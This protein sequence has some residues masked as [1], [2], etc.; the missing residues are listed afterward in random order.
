MN[1]LRTDF[2]RAEYLVN[3][4]VSAAT[5]KERDD[6]GFKAF[7]KHFLADGNLQALL[8]DWLRTCRTLE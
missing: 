7:R 6:D 2:E 8:P 3:L 1:E 5:G 4:L